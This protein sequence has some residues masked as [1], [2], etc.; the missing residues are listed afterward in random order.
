MR[1][2]LI[3]LEMAW[4]D[5]KANHARASRLLTHAAHAGARLAILPEM[6]ATGF[7]MHPEK[8]AQEPG[9]MTETWL[10]ST[11]RGLGIHVLAGVAQTASPLPENRALLVSPD[12]EVT[13]YAKI[14]PFSFSGEDRYYGAGARV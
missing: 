2:A 3:Q 13:R 7:S 4:E 8:I 9:G 11:A 1:V 6:F 12:G 14:H 10:V 5:P